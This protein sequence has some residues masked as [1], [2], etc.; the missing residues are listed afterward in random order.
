MRYV[1]AT[2]VSTI[3]LFV[4]I[5]AALIS[6]FAIE[7]F[8]Y[9]IDIF[10]R[11]KIELRILAILYASI[12]PD[13]A[14]FILPIAVVLA[15]YLVILRK[16]E[17][18]EFLVLSSAGIGHRHLLLVGFGTAIVA[19][20]LCGL[21][22]GF[23]KPYASLA[24]RG[25]Y[26]QA[27]ANA[28]S[29][30]MPGGQIY[31]QDEN[32]MFV[33][34]PAAGAET[35]MRV[36]GFKGERLERLTISDCANLRA[37]GERILAELCDARIYL[38]GVDAPGVRGAASA[39]GSTEADCRLCMTDEGK[40]DVARIQVGRSSL[41]FDMATLLGQAPEP[42]G[43]DRDLVDLL[44]MTDGRFRSSADARM[45]GSRIVLALTCLFAVGAALGAVAATQRRTG[46]LALALAIALVI[47]AIVV[48]RSEILFTGS[49]RDPLVF[50][51]RLAAV[52]AVCAGSV[53]AVVFGFHRRLVTPMFIQA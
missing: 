40:L 34:A 14:D 28:L 3:V 21:L 25:Y 33:S 42:Y 39:P 24:F 18:R 19:V 38:F 41:A 44:G 6:V 51:L 7:K 8:S 43:T 52:L 50:G 20:V 37:F 12:L 29:K 30:G 36:F 26:A 27:F 45:A 46:P 15:T 47:A 17:A 32:F 13:V 16:R 2:I 9:I 23:V 5:F 49:M 48:A 4:A 22:S 31:R 35:Q 53:I 1:S 11:F 10:L